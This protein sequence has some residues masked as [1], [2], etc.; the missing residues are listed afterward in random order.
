[1]MI[2]SP[3]KSI[4]DEVR[5]S[6][7]GVWNNPITLSG[8]KETSESA[9]WGDILGEPE[10]NSDSSDNQLNLVGL[11]H[12]SSRPDKKQSLEETVRELRI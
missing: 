12:T 7:L 8:D 3:R 10:D 1:M 4:T 2:R 6:D 11:M 5:S 9:S